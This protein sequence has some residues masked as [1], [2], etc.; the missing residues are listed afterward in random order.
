MGGI[1]STGQDGFGNPLP[2]LKDGEHRDVAP[3]NPISVVSLLVYT[4]RQYLSY[5]SQER[6]PWLWDA[7]L[8]PED[9]ED[10]NVPIEESGSA[11]KILIEPG[12][13]VEK[14]SRNYRPAI[15]VDRGTVRPIKMAINNFVGTQFQTGLKAYHCLY[16]MDVIVECHSDVNNESCIIADTVGDYFLATRDVFRETLG[17]HE[18]T[19]PVI[20]ET[21]PNKTDNEY[22]ITPVQFSV[23]YD[24]RWGTKPITPI[25]REIA[26]KL[27]DAENPDDIYLELVKRDEGLP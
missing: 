27:R 6:L 21:R 4:L 14:S 3:S 24:K 1:I 9:T 5:D 23:Q 2:R 19:E 15:Y 12:F 22:W 10:G 11:R 26:V 25:A 18:L 13:N 17:L 20:G 8:R 7:L 16:N